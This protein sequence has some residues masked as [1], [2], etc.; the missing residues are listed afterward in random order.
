MAMLCTRRNTGASLPEVFP[1][2]PVFG[3]T[4][5]HMHPFSERGTRAFRVMAAILPQHSSPVSSLDGSRV[6]SLG[7]PV[8][9]SGAPSSLDGSNGPDSDQRSVPLYR[10]AAD[11]NSPTPQ[12]TNSEM[13]FSLEQE[14]G[15][16]MCIM[17]ELEEEDEHD[18]DEQRNDK[19]YRLEEVLRA[20]EASVSVHDPPEELPAEEVAALAAVGVC[21]LCAPCPYVETTEFS[22]VVPYV[23][24]TVGTLATRYME[25]KCGCA[26][27]SC[28]EGLTG[29]QLKQAYAETHPQHSATPPGVVNSKLHALLWEMKEP[30]PR[31]TNGRGHTHRLRPL[32]YDGKPLCARGW[33][34]LRGAAPWGMRQAK[35]LVLRGISPAGV[36]A[37]RGAALVVAAATRVEAEAS[38]K[39]MRTTEW[40]KAKYLCTMEYMPNENRIVLRGASTT[41]VHRE[42][43]T[44]EARKGG[45]YLSYKQFMCCMHA[46][47]VAAVE[48]D[49]AVGPEV[50]HKVKVSRSAKHSNFPMCT[51]CD[52]LSHSYIK[53]Y[54]DP[55]ADPVDVEMALQLLLAHQT[56]FMADRTFAR[57]LRYATYDARVSSDLYECDDKCGSFWCKIPVVG[58][59]NKENTKQV[60]EFAVQA[61]VVCGP[62]G[63]V[64]MSIIPKTVNT[65]ANF[66]LSTLLGGLYSAYKAG[67]LKPH[68]RR[69]IRH[70]D[71]GSDNVAKVTHIFNWLLVY[72]G[73]WE[74]IL[75][76][77]FDAG[78]SHTEIAD[79][80]FSLMKKIFETDGAAHVEGGVLTFEEL[81]ERLKA[82]FSKCPEMKEIV[83]HFANWN[84]ATWLKASV[85]FKES[86][87]ELIKFDNVYRYQYVGDLSCTD[88]KGQPSTVARE[89]GGVQVTYKRH[90]SD[91]AT[92]YYDDE[93]APLQRVQESSAT[94]ETVVANRTIPAGVVFVAQPP[95][96][97]AEPPREETDEKGR[98]HGREAIRRVLARKDL[99]KTGRE[100]AFWHALYYM[101]GSGLAEAIPN[102]PCSVSAAD[103]S[104]DSGSLAD[105]GSEVEDGFYKFDFKGSSPSPFLPMLKEMVRFE[106][107]YI[108]WPIWTE[109]PPLAFPSE[110]RRMG[111]EAQAL[112][113]NHE[114]REQAG[115]SAPLRELGFRP[116]CGQCPRHEVAVRR[117]WLC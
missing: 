69:L 77:I 5:L 101:H 81:E 39:Q 22:T 4:T 38:E 63:V 67:R 11:L 46:A 53:A 73:C 98:D 19:E 99:P 54:S 49:H 28:L 16:L 88:S 30:L 114:T 112:A 24:E 43:Y 12:L 79:R 23:E 8:L 94:G 56:Q 44:I 109:T 106:R 21:G 17:D 117:P 58:R 65:G 107:P 86:D 104:R 108:T 35:G 20:A 3:K 55:L 29:S 113:G 18:E 97:T 52:D 42:Q 64:R 10:K 61:N 51:T 68:V 72:V 71:G 110:P 34:V 91:K 60:Y 26:G 75:W 115:G 93:W 41:F 2:L 100:R 80:L 103:H 90:L 25:F 66:G 116:L 32:S 105:E 62:G 89:H 27:G 14:V 6:S 48:A 95:N 36:E 1:S 96:L 102:L 84:F 74:D 82:C 76:F 31:G 78:H 13:P 9:P 45:Y 50:S 59:Q 37:E 47:A 85:G 111:A 33:R 92:S 83:Y 7:S 70:T 40:L 87:L 15:T 57:R